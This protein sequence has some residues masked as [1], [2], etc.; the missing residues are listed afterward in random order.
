MVDFGDSIVWKYKTVSCEYCDKPFN[1]TKGKDLHIKKS[2]KSKISV[3][4]GPEVI[5]DEN[6]NQMEPKPDKDEDKKENSESVNFLELKESEEN[7]EEIEA[8][9][10]AE[11]DN[12]DEYQAFEEVPY[13]GQQVL[14]SRYVITKKDDGSVKPR[15]VIKGFQEEDKA[16]ADSPTASRETLKLFLSIVAN[17]KWTLKSYDVRSAFLQSDNI[18]RE[19]YVKPPPERARNGIV[20]KLK[21][22]V[23]GLVDASRQWF[24]T[25]KDFL[26]SL[27]MKQSLGDSCLFY[28]R[29][30][31]KLEGIIISHVDD[32]LAA[33]SEVFHKNIISP[34]LNKFSFGK[35]SETEFKYTG[36]SVYQNNHKTIF[37]DQN[38]FIKNLPI[39]QYRRQDC[40]N[41]LEK[42]E[43]TLLRKTTGQLNWLSSQTR[44]DLAYDAYVLST[45]LNKAKYKDAKY[46]SKVLLKSKYEEVQLK[47]S[48]LDKWE[49]L[50]LELYVDAALGN[51]EQD[52]KTKSMMGYI[53]LLCDKYGNFNPIHWKSK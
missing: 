38:Q 42:D 32:F 45:C 47:F 27:G 29:M 12:F 52:G 6:Q 8:A 16:Q 21:K 23:Y 17:E 9:K 13:N 28:Y 53:L 11:M 48:H 14:G 15:F 1:N 2:H 33:G 3:R 44:P 50:H 7:K 19:V 25:I 43:N 30:E 31:E 34:M 20:W 18:K 4:F 24:L 51:V 39:F 22:P 5:M 41:I 40:E 37:I 49:D 10:K 26:T 36:I 35:I 46:A